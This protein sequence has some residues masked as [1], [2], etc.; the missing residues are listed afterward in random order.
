ML[1]RMVTRDRSVQKAPSF[2]IVGK[3]YPLG[4]SSE[5]AFVVKDYSVSRNHAEIIVKHDSILVNDLRSLNGT[6]VNG[7]RIKQ[8]EVQPGQDVAFGSVQFQLTNMEAPEI[9]DEEESELSTLALKP[10][11]GLHPAVLQQLSQGQR[12]VLN[13]LLAGMSEKEAAVALELSPHTV[14]NHVKTIYFRLNVS[15]RAELLALF[16]SKSKFKKKLP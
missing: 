8:A 13:A 12:R 10:N 3:K 11:A 5:C 6:F 9:D 7:A 14:H 1:L 15:S 4:R 2:L 16:V